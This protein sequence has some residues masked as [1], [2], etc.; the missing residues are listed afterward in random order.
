MFNA[1]S[2]EGTSINEIIELV[3]NITGKEV[4]VGY[5]DGRSLDVQEVV[6]DIGRVGKQIGWKP[7]ISLTDGIKDQWQWI[8]SSSAGKIKG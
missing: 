1:G 4:L 3:R 6:L 5:Q 8:K 2:G 7:E